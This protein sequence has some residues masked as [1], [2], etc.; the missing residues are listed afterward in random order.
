M[1]PYVYRGSDHDIVSEVV[2]LLE[3]RTGD[4]RT[5]KCMCCIVYPLLTTI[6]FH[7]SYVATWC[8]SYQ[9]AV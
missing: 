2:K 5:I 3:T 4:G 6:C 7:E 8:S 9:K 1:L